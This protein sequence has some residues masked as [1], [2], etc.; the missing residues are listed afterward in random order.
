MRTK[1]SLLFFVV[2][3][4]VF[5][6]GCL[7][8]SDRPAFEDERHADIHER[9][10]DSMD[11]ETAA[12]FEDAITADGE[13]TPQGE[14][15]L[16][17][18]LAIEELGVDQRDATARS[19]AERGTVDE[20]TVAA[21]DRL[22]AS[23]ESVQERVFAAGVA[24]TAGDGLLD[25]EKEL[26]GLD[27]ATPHPT[28]AEIATT[29]GADGYDANELAYLD[30]VAELSDDEFVLAQVRA[31]AETSTGDVTEKDLQKLDD[32]SGDG[33]LT[34]TANHLGLDPTTEHETVATVAE[35]LAT[36][37]YDET[38]LAFLDR[39]ADHRDDEFAWRQ[40]ELTLDNQTA[41]GTVTERDV[42]SLTDENGDGLLTVTTERFGLDAD[43]SYPDIAR[44]T[45]QF[46]RGGFESAELAYLDAATDVRADTFRW[47]QLQTLESVALL[48]DADDL[49]ADDT[50]QLRDAS[51]DGLLDAMARAFDASPEERHPE[52]V[53]LTEPLLR[54]EFGTTEE[55]YLHRLQELGQYRDH[56]TGYEVWSQAERLGLLHEATANGT[57]TDRQLWELGNDDA[58]RLLNGME[59][60]LGTDPN[61]ADTSG[62][63]LPDHLKW[64]PLADL[65]LD[66][67]PAEVDV[68]VE[69]DTAADVTI[70]DDGYASLDAIAHTF[71]TEPDDHIPPITLHF[72]QCRTGLDSIRTI[73]GMQQVAD[74]H[75]ELTGL[76]FHYLFVNDGRL[77]DGNSAYKG[78]TRW[79][80]AEHSWMMAN[81]RLDDRDLINTIAHEIGHKVGLHPRDFG[82]ID[83]REYSVQEYNSVMNYNLDVGVTFSTDEPFDDYQQM[84]RE[85]FGSR[86]ESVDAL[87]RMWDEGVDE[88][89]LC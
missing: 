38:E 88:G 89:A 37:G 24:D 4:I 70:P 13:L 52:L 30:R 19:I 51:G 36:E 84:V 67:T 49:T 57:V 73:E 43:E 22:L 72:R 50:R 23:P 65:G 69:L 6:T 41:D 39:V 60:E 31:M 61:A 59:V 63:G 44:L 76:G 3:L 15:V 2:I 55:Q 48:D 75:K 32:E 46:A 54:G 21:M 26:F 17:R 77:V 85:E 33:L 74:E 64:G 83:S 40:L 66:V 82:G 8:V 28:V 11:E 1:S 68:L 45:E 53:A 86:W 12:A 16:D 35:A 5:F 62:D 42:H 58:D 34:V 81:A 56:G 10:T 79:R 18:L 20:G 7:A 80:S 71:E 25:G 87:D 14:A 78:Y 27:P 9:V 29:L 47:R